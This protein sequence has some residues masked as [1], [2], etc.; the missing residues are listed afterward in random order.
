MHYYTV[1]NHSKV[2][3]IFWISAISVL[4]TPVV[5]QFVEWLVDKN[6]TISNIYHQLGIIGISFS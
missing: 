1:R 2:H 5:N 6:S 4:I 3:V